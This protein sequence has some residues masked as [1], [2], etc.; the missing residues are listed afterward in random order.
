MLT[1]TIKLC[2]EIIIEE[3]FFMWWVYELFDDLYGNYVIISK[4]VKIF[5]S[6]VIFGAVS[7][8][9]TVIHALSWRHHHIERLFTAIYRE[10]RCNSIPCCLNST[11]EFQIK[12]K[13]LRKNKSVWHKNLVSVSLH[14]HCILC[15]Q[16]ASQA[17]AN[18][19]L[20]FAI[21]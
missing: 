4:C 15:I 2:R 19:F 16:Y 18:I 13:V 7:G 14:Y 10:S 5:N 11:P 3:S 6:K 9:K 1:N 8:W 12:V 17:K 20:L 21:I